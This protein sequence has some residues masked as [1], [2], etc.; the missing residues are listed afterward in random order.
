MLGLASAIS[1][2]RSTR[3]GDSKLSVVVNSICIQHSKFRDKPLQRQFFLQ[4]KLKQN[5]TKMSNACE[6]QHPSYV[7]V[8]EISLAKC[9]IKSG[10]GKQRADDMP[11]VH[12]SFDTKLFLWKTNPCF[13]WAQTSVNFDG[14]HIAT[15]TPNKSVY[16]ERSKA[17]LGFPLTR[18][19]WMG[20]LKRFRK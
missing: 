20:R 1:R 10:I 7:G 13:A 6:V 8:I 3:R 17:L 5:M 4:K 11:W 18:D 9:I 14:Q 2:L 16:S 19:K 15:V 12:H